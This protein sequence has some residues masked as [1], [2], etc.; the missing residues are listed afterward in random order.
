MDF[1]TYT[2]K[3]ILVE[4]YIAKKWANTPSALALKL[5]ISERTVLRMVE[6]L[7]SEGK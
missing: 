7:K 3:M 6:Y 1:K 4:Q 2:K 5:A